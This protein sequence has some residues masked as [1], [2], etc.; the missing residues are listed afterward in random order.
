MERHQKTCVE[1]ML[2]NF[3]KL[4]VL[5]RAVLKGEPVELLIWLRGISSKLLLERV[6]QNSN[7]V[8]D[9]DGAGEVLGVHELSIF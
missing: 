1:K 2:L 4:S 6:R 5:D 7:Y 9:L 8:A 3:L